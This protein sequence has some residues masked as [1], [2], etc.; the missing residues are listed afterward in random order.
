MDINIIE[1]LNKIEELIKKQTLL[2]KTV[3]NVSEAAD[4]LAISTSHLYKLTSNREI[5]FSCPQGKRIYFNREELDEW[6]QRN[7]FEAQ[8]NFSVDMDNYSRKVPY[9]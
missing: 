7:K 5:P 3:L 8:P 2:Q 4:Y 1:K 9:N 6:L